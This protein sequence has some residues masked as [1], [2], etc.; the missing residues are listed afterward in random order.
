MSS[1]SSCAGSARELRDLAHGIR[2]AALGAGGLA[3]ALP[4]LV[5]RTPVPAT[6]AVEVG[7]LPPAVEA[8]V[9]FVCAEALTNISK[10]ARASAASVTVGHGQGSVVAR[11]VDDGVGCVDLRGGT[12][13]RGLAD[14]VEALGGRFVVEAPAGGGTAVMAEVPTNETG[15]PP[16]VT[17]AGSR[18]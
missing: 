3:A 8:A 17:A 13:L 15:G 12:G 5:A 11:I 14:R 7:R 1:G 10:H 18:A 2:P 9:F 16:D 6:V 4:I